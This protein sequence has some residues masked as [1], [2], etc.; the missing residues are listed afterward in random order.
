MS[1]PN[2][3]DMIVV[4]AGLVGAVTALGLAEQ[5]YRVAVLEQRPPKLNQGTSGY[6]PRTVALS[7]VSQRLLAR[8]GIWSELTPVA[9][10]HMQVWED[11]GTARIEFSAADIQVD[12]LG[13]IVE[14]SPTV[15]ALWAALEAH[16]GISLFTGY[17][18]DGITPAV[19]SVQLG[20]NRDAVT[21]EPVAS[22]DERIDLTAKLLVAADGA[23]SRIRSLLKV[24]AERSQT[25]HHAMATI[26][27]TERLHHATSYQRFLLDGPVALLPVSAEGQHS[28]LVWSQSP[29]QAE[30]RMQLGDAAF[31]LELEYATEACLGAIRAVDRRYSFP[32]TQQVVESFNPEARVLIIGDAARVVHPLAGQGVNLGFEDALALLDAAAKLHGEDPGASPLWQRF[33]RAR[34][35]RSRFMIG[36]MQGFQSVYRSDE[37]LLQLLRNVGVG[38]IN[39]SPLLK[40][41]LMK[42]ALGLGKL[43]RI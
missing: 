23:N 26:V 28:A 20:L 29:A 16:A 11:Q 31:C 37:P 5:G 30:R 8:F 21:K 12:A 6:D 22:K 14:V 19:E 32:L 1:R 4:G 41:Q 34:R 13:W 33:A 17:G 15:L 10:Q 27:E 3:F 39:E 25:G 36:L 43:A 18:I 42:E 38:L 2:D 24:G 7:P 9:Y 35:A 40:H